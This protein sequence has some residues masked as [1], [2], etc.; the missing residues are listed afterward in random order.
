MN[1]SPSNDLDLKPLLKSA[2]YMYI[3]DIFTIS[4]ACMMCSLP[5]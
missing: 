5:V 1:K 2:I 4:I 3:T